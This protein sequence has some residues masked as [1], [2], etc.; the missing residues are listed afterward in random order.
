MNR[1]NIFRLAL[2]AVAASAMEV[3][4]MKPITAPVVEASLSTVDKLFLRESELM[5]RYLDKQAWLRHQVE[6]A[7]SI[8]MADKLFPRRV[9]Q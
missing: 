7:S 5:L 4:G 6:S 1:R 3:F 8:E 2:C 9:D